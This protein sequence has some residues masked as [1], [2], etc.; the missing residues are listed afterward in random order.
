[1]LGQEDY[2]GY[3]RAGRVSPGAILV[4]LGVVFLLLH[5]LP[6]GALPLLALGGVFTALSLGRGARGLLLPGTIL[7]GLGGGIVA[8]SLLGH[9]SGAL[10]GAA[11]F[12]GLGTGFWAAS[13]LDRARHPYSPAFGWARVP[14]SLLLGFAGFLAFLGATSLALRWW[15]LLLIVGGV[16]LYLGGRRKRRADPWA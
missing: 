3:G 9:L 1:M 14:G 10:G 16:W 11:V 7:L 15:P 6:G 4:G 5:L 12:G 13:L 8:A 2:G